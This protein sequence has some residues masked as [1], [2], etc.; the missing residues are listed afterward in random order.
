M[1]TMIFIFGFAKN[2]LLEKSYVSFMVKFE[3]YLT[4]D[5]RLSYVNYN[6]NTRNSDTHYCISIVFYIG[7]VYRYASNIAQIL[8]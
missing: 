3:L 2:D 7:K 8:P 1:M 5:Y 4:R 6:R